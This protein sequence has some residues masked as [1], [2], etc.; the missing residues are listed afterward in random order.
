MPL[1]HL[2]ISSAVALALALLPATRDARADDTAAAA[3][4]LFDDAVSLMAEK[5]YDRA[6]PKLDEVVRL[7]P[8]K[9]GAGMQRAQ[10]YEDWGKLAT[11]WSAYRSVGD[12]ARAAG[13]ARAAKAEAKV[14]ELGARAPRLTVTV[15][16]GSR[17]MRGLSVER[18]GVA[19]GAAVW[20]TALP[21]DPGEH[22][23]VAS[24]PGKQRWTRTVLLAADAAPMTVTVPA[25]EDEAP[26]KPS[27]AAPPE[28]IP[29]QAKGLSGRVPVW[30]WGVGGAG[31]AAA[32]VAAGFAV[33]WRMAQDEL[34]KQ[35]GATLVCRGAHATPGTQLNAQ[36]DRDR[37][38]FAAV[39]GVGVAAVVVAVV[40]IATRPKQA[41]EGAASV[42]WAPVLGPSVV[43]LSWQGVF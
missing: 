1:P 17:Y 20:D 18:N 27:P 8:R 37:I 39:G 28:A 34:V 32:G 38:I 12:L 22:V 15:A 9:V 31:L 5:A 11:A 4:A 13:D 40:G 21:V 33:D 3:Q 43:G 41:P 25:L 14:K 23:I 7:Q 2:R 6:C 29:V 16:P 19:V 30:A 36:Q 10:C 26:E 24:A 42:G 35:C